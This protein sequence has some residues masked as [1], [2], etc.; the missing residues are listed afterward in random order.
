LTIP[1]A[2]LTAEP[3]HAGSKWRVNFS[4]IDRPRGR[5]RELSAWAPTQLATFHAPERFGT[6]CFA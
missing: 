4:R 5:E 2:S 6:L 1:F 3:P